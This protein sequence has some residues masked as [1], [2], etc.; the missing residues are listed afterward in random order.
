MTGFKLL[1]VFFIMYALFFVIG[2]H[3]FKAIQKQQGMRQKLFETLEPAVA[4]GKEPDQEQ[5]KQILAEIKKN[6]P[7]LP[8]LGVT[9]KNLNDLV[10]Q[11][12]EITQAEILAKGDRITADDLGEIKHLFECKESK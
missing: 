9:D 4:K 12:I 1:I 3:D 7:I 11:R 8:F 6:Q 5:I 10:C 2:V